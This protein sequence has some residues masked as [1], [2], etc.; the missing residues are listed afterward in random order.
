[1][2]FNY[3]ALD[4]QGKAQTGVVN[5][6]NQDAA[7]VTLQRRGLTITAITSPGKREWRAL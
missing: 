2:E 7:I 3:Q 1:M 4:S 6:T 5:A